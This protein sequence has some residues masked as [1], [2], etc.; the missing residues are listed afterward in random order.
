MRE[1]CQACGCLE[2]TIITKN[3]QDVCGVP[4]AGLTATAHR[5]PKRAVSLGR[6]ALA[7]QSGRGSAP[8]F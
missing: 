2:G 7:R 6:Y 8:A 4:I 5:V 1:P 3:G